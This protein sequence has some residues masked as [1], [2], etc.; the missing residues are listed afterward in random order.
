[1][2]TTDFKCYMISNKPEYYEQVKLNILPYHLEFYDGTNIFSFA[3]L[4]NSCVEQCPTEIIVMMSDKVMPTAYDVK[5]TIDLINQGYGFV[6]LYLFS[7]FGFHKD[8]FRTVGPLDEKFVSGGYEDHD[9][10]LRLRENNVSCYVS[11][12]V[13]YLKR[14]S[15][16]DYSINKPY[17]IEKWIPNYSHRILFE[18]HME[19]RIP[20]VKNFRNFGEYKG[21]KFLPWDNKYVHSKVA[22]PL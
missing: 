12:E 21:T 13:E 10:Y 5:K 19:R 20:E 8:L 9:Y 22:L 16:Y 17:F 2:E 7:F 1:M 4:V 18:N 3:S 15:S 6:G 14:K 11:H